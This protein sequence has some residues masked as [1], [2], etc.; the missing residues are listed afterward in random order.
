MRKLSDRALFVLSYASVVA[1]AMLLIFGIWALVSCDEPLKKPAPCSRNVKCQ[2]MAFSKAS[3][4][5]KLKV[6]QYDTAE[7]EYAFVISNLVE[8]PLE[9][10]VVTREDTK[11]LLVDDGLEIYCASYQWNQSFETCK[12]FI[13]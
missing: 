4:F 8:K 2:K 13:P 3:V 9:G 1:G 6:K 7:S 12:A 11:R 10:A 5:T